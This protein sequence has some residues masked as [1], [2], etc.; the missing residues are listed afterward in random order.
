MKREV[1]EWRS[2]VIAVSAALALFGCQGSITLADPVEGSTP[3]N[4][5]VGPD[6]TTPVIVRPPDEQP[7]VDDEEVAEACEFINPGDTPLHRMTRAEYVNTVRD[8]FDGV[9]F[10]VGTLPGDERVGQFSANTVASVDRVGVEAYQN[11]AEAIAD[12]VMG[13]LDKVVDCASAQ[14]VNIGRF[15]AENLNGT[16]GRAESDS[17]LIWS[18]GSVS[19]GFQTQQA[20]AVQFSIRAWGSRAGSDLPN[21]RVTVNGQNIGDVAVDAQRDNPQVYTVET[22]LDAGS[23]SVQVAFT[24]DFNQNGD[25][26]NLWVDYIDVTAQ[27]VVGGDRA[28]AEQYVDDVVT[29]AFRRPLEG[30]ERDRLLGMFDALNTEHGFLEGMRGLVEVTLQSP[31]FLYRVEGGVASDDAVVKL[32]DYE[33]AS[34]LSYFLWNTMPDEAL[35]D[36]AA[37]GELSTMSGVEAQARRMLADDKAR[38]AINEAMMELMELGD[39]EVLAKNDPVFTPRVR[40]AM[41]AEMLAFVDEVIWGDGEG[42]GKLTT[43]LT[44]NFAYVSRE[45]APLYGVDAPQGGGM[46]RVVFEDGSRAGILTQLAVLAQH[47]HGQ[48]P[49]FRGKIV[50]DTLL[51]QEPLVVPKDIPEPPETSAEM[52][53]RDIAEARMEANGCKGCHLAMDP[54]G[55]V[56]SRYDELGRVQDVD[57]YGNELSSMGGLVLNNVTTEMTS[58]AEFADALAS[59]DEVKACFTR[60]GLRVALG[61]FLTRDDACTL[62]VL[63]HAA[64]QS[65]DDIREMFVAI[66]TTDAFR[67]RRALGATQE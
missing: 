29:R 39:F 32:T 60:Q 55:L 9:T 17:W 1:V 45:T 6:G 41:E 49:V 7:P 47:G 34:R 52:S 19:T 33:M 67:F 23:H 4:T 11:N 40:E 57:E 31:K 20:G 27:G 13:Q 46:E 43:L 58:P 24:N 18:N 26:R 48:M 15:E 30:A 3:G 62:A 38:Q 14:S 66:T 35:L 65:N 63:E 2:K 37:N 59:S 22:D 54:M 36:A 25:D 42:A 10:G 16:A 21:M 56:Y 61:R 28:C 53:L 44:A 8:L 12:E 50:R 51:C 5:V 64:E